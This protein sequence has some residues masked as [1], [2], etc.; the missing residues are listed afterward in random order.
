M[1]PGR[2][3]PL[4]AGGALGVCCRTGG[5]ERRERFHHPATIHGGSL[6]AF[7]RYRSPLRANSNASKL[8]NWRERAI[9]AYASFNGR[10]KIR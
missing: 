3:H 4:Y 2:K 1:T 5:G 10:E 8:R 7:P 9:A 6:R